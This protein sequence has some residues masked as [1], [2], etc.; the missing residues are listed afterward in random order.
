ME[1]RLGLASRWL[2]A[3]SAVVIPLTVIVLVSGSWAVNYQYN[4][5]QWTKYVLFASWIL[6]TL[7]LVAGVTNLISP[8]LEADAAGEAAAAPGSQEGETPEGE[9]VRIGPRPK[10]AVDFNYA[11]LLGQAAA[12][13]LGMTLYVVY[14][15]WMVL[16][17]KPLPVLGG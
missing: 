12:F 6:F 10:P 8:P 9:E 11:M 13:M 16:S 15:S 7:S 2:T 17:V 14:I 3:L 4:T 5:A 1:E